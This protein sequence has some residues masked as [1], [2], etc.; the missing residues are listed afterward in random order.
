MELRFKWVQRP[1]HSALSA[2]GTG[3]KQTRQLAAGDKA[4]VTGS[5]VSRNGDLVHVRDKKSG[6]VVVVNITDNT[7]IERKKR[8][9][10]FPRHTDMDVT[11]ML[12]GSTIEAVGVGNS[13]GQLDAAA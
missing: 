1:I 9:V 7:R 4:R 6:E 5:I 13:K 2:S 11:A 10:L 3:R 8:S 12:P